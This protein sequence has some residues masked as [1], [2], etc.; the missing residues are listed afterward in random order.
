MAKTIAIDFD[1]VIHRY[2]KGWHDGTIYDEPVRGALEYIKSLMDQGYC[3]YVLSTRNPRQIKRWLDHYT[4]KWDSF[5]KD[6][7]L[8]FYGYKPEIVPFW[9]NIWDKPYALGITNRKLPAMAY[10]DDKAV[11]FEGRWDNL[12]NAEVE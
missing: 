8:A 3:V 9:K 12:I 2:S 4:W 1:G 5:S 7:Q 10:I 6:D 11:R